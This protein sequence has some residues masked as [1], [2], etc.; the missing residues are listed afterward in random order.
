MGYYKRENKSEEDVQK[1]IDE[2]KSISSKPIQDH[3]FNVSD[4]LFLVN[5]ADTLG[6]KIFALEGKKHKVISVRFYMTPTDGYIY[7]IHLVCN[8]TRFR[9]YNGN[10]MTVFIRTGSIFIKTL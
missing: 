5:L 1:F 6:R 3:F 4:E 8:M 7:N 2:I 9:N 10:T